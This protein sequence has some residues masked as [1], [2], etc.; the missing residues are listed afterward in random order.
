MKKAIY[1]CLAS[2]LLLAG[3]SG[4]A[5]PAAS[6]AE[7]T[8]QA[9][10]AE[11]TVEAPAYYKEYVQNPQ[12]TNDRL[13][14]EVGQSAR[15]NKGEAQLKNINME[16]Q[17]FEIGG[18][19][20]TIREAKVFHFKPDY[21]LIDF[22]HSYT[23]DTEFDAAKLFVEIENTSSETLRFAPVALLETDAEETKTWEDDIYLEELNGEI[24][25]GEK[26]AGN[27]G[28]IIEKGDTGSLTVTTSDVFG[29]EDKKLADAQKIKLEF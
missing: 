7:E 18:I 21:S 29:K 4:Q 24:A 12:V 1:L 8:A 10:A 6:A 15:D 5:E 11:K 23:H 25:A 3:C 2:A 19:K 17:T 27:L 28:F 9:S 26:K 14:Q 22:Y 13:L 16:A 20:L